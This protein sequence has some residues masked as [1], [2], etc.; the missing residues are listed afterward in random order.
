MSQ[1]PF[2][3][4]FFSTFEGKADNS[5]ATPASTSF[6]GVAIG[7]AMYSVAPML[8][9]LALLTGV[10]SVA[11]GVSMHKEIQF[12]KEFKLTQFELMKENLAAAKDARA[13]RPLQT[14]L[15]KEQLAAAK[16]GRL[17]RQHKMVPERVA[18]IA[19]SLAGL[20]GLDHG[21]HQ[22]VIDQLT[23]A[24]KEGIPSLLETARAMNAG[25]DK[26]DLDYGKHHDAGHG[27]SR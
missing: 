9:P 17:D 19:K 1:H 10:A 12:E 25:N 26:P 11:K 18:N 27:Y 13:N 2:D 14:E 4:A 23:T 16:D 7:A 3:R 24:V 22:G 15:L 5:P 8:F 20:D 6:A 21:K